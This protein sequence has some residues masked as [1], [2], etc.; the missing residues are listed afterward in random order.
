MYR[1]V[2]YD[3]Q[4]L[5]RVVFFVVLYTECSKNSVDRNILSALMDSV[6]FILFFNVSLKLETV[7]NRLRIPSSIT[8][9]QGI[10]QLFT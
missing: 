8:L 9:N 6:F 3:S 4:N 5:F 2:T 10:D 1:T 7:L